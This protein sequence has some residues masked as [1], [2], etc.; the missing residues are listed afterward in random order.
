MMPSPA[1]A[2]RPPALEMRG[3]GKRFGSV[4]ANRGVDLH[5]AA[6]SIHGLIGE[7]GEKKEA[8]LVLRSFYDEMAAQ[9]G[10]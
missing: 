3:I 2:D 9:Y 5:V 6:G 7:N 1:G 10:P 8:F 4:H